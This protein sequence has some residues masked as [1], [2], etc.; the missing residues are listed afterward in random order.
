MKVKIQDKLKQ[1]LGG[2]FKKTKHKKN[3]KNMHATCHE[4]F[5]FWDGQGW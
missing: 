1:S 5:F 3:K 4:L 2:A